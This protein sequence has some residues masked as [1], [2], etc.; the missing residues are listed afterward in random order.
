SE[1]DRRLPMSAAF[2]PDGRLWR[3]SVEGKQVL[4]D[5]SGDDGKTF[6]APTAVNQAP[7][8]VRVRAEDRPQI[9]VDAGGVIHVVYSAELPQPSSSYYSV[10]TD[11]GKSF[12]EPVLVSDTAA[13]ANTYENNV[14]VTPD[15]RV[16]VF[17]HDER[18]RADWR[19]AGASIYYAVGGP[20]GGLSK[21]SRK[22]AGDICE[23]CR[24][25]VKVDVDGSP[26]LF[27][28]AIYSGTVRDHGLIKLNGAADAWSSS[29]VSHDE[30]SIGVCPEQGPALSIGPDGRYHATWFSQG[31]KGS[32]L[33][34]A[35]SSD[36]GA[37]FSPPR[38]FGDAG[39]LAG[40]P[41][42]LSLG[43]KVAV[44]WQE[45]DGKEK[46]IQAMLSTDGGEHWSAVKTLGRT[47]SEADYPLLVGDGQRIFLQWTTRRD[48]FQMLRVE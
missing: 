47:E 6:A 46:R 5:V 43:A 21:S 48:G 38:S 28:R 22:A 34:Y 26:V 10:S 37:H 39:A 8:R 44:A 20:A 32:G 3:V 45:F 27:A 1:E 17:W 7:Q 35:Y 13:E 24:T 14:L 25:A 36:H 33:F 11:G 4:V 15:R 41:S 16:F 9:A 42:V 12:S 29:R 31:A 2:G 23:C 40:H 19:D 18:D 30:W